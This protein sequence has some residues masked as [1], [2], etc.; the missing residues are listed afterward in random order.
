MKRNAS[1]NS[2]STKRIEIIRYQIARQ[3]S[4]E[5]LPAAQ[6]ED[7]YS[8]AFVPYCMKGSATG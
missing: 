6:T 5:E 8:I 2:P 7:V 4:E 3:L 1:Y